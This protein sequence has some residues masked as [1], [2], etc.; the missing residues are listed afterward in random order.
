MNSNREVKSQQIFEKKGNNID[1]NLLKPIESREYQVLSDLLKKLYHTNIES[2]EKILIIGD[3]LKEIYLQLHNISPKVQFYLANISNEPLESF[4]RIYKNYENYSTHI[5]DV[6]KGVSLH[7]FV[8]YNDKFDLVIANKV[9]SNLS[10]KKRKLS[11]KFLYKH[12]L[13]QNGILCIISYIKDTNQ[14]VK[15]NFMRNIKPVLEKESLT[16]NKKSSIQFSF[17]MRK[18]KYF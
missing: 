10:K 14:D 2:M 15:N 6:S 3:S 5:L 13:R 12:Y 11:L 17:Y 8:F 4:K 7:D 18:K 1:K 9:Y 16:K